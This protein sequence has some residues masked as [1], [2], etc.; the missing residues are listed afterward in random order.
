MT[1]AHISLR[2]KRLLVL[3]L[4][5]VGALAGTV[6]ATALGTGT[7]SAAP[8]GSGHGLCFDINSPLARDSLSRIGRDVNG[9]SWE[10]ARA[11]TNPL[12]GGCDLDWM[13]VNGNGVGDAT[14][15]SRVLLFSNGRFLGTVDPKPY[16]YTSIAGG[17]RDYVTVR[18]RWLRPGDAF[19][20]ASGGPTDVTA[21]AL[22]GNVIRLGSFPPA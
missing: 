6:S 22:G 19:C 15:Q 5:V 17:T 8:Y 2:V 7:A 9:G 4:A 21:F 10:P 14:Y 13:L 12:S 1:P 11:S 20:C 16:S 3:C 18:Y